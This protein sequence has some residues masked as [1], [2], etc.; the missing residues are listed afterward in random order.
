MK[1]SC[2]IPLTISAAAPHPQW[3]CCPVPR[4]CGEAASVDLQSHSECLTRLPACPEFTV[5]PVIPGSDSE[6]P[7]L[8]ST[9]SSPSSP[10]PGDQMP[11]HSISQLSAV[12]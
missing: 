12:V 9:L 8:Q 1:S 5:C 7:S 2:L 10:P 3:T 11:G 4:R 6:L